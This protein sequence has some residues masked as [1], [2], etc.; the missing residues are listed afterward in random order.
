[1]E[2]VHDLVYHGGGGFIYSDV[3][4][5]PIMTRRYHIRKINDFLQKKADAEEKAMN[6]NSGKVSA[7]DYAGKVPVPDFIS[8]IKKS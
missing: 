8:K 7:R 6:S 5:M 2:E 4:V 1:M 3:W